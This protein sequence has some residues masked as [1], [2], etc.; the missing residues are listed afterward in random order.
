MVLF[1]S[2]KYG[3]RQ[4]SMAVASILL[5]QA[6]TVISTALLDQESQQVSMRADNLV[7]SLDFMEVDNATEFFQFYDVL[8]VSKYPKAS[9]M[10]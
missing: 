9:Y 6:A 2:I 5:L 7:K 10:P 3:H 1:S 4:I 8:Y